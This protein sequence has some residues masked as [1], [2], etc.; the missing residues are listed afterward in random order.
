MKGH[1]NEPV[2]I[3]VMRPQIKQ[4]AELSNI[5][6][7]TA[8]AI[9]WKAYLRNHPNEFRAKKPVKEQGHE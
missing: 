5:D 6:L 8:Y 1:M 9:L 2:S 7:K 4:K 3:E